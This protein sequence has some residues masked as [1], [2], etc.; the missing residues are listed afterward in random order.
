M[1]AAG[2]G[3]ATDGLMKTMPVQGQDLLAKVAGALSSQ[4]Q[5]KPAPEAAPSGNGAPVGLAGTAA[6]VSPTAAATEVR[7]SDSRK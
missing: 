2:L 1:R 4:L 7:R 3:L 6:D 5:P